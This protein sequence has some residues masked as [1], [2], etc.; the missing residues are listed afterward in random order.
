M[1]PLFC[2]DQP[3]ATSVRPTFIQRLLHE[4]RYISPGPTAT[5][6]FLAATGKTLVSVWK[7]EPG[8]GERL[9]ERAAQTSPAKQVV[10]GPEFNS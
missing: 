6:V 2:K 7:R 8:A 9:N 3:K 4:Y 1:S 10:V 5:R